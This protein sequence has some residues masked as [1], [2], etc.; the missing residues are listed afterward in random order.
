MKRGGFD[1]IIGNPPW[2][3]LSGKFGNQFLPATALEY[4]VS[5][6]F[7]NTYMPNMY[8]YFVARGLGLTKMS[9]LVGYIVP[10]RLGF[11]TQFIQLRRR[12]VKDAQIVTLYY[13]VPFPGVIAD[14]LVFVIRKGPAGLSHEVEISEYGHAAVRI[15]QSDFSLSPECRFEY[16][17]DTRQEQ[18]SRRIQSMPCVRPLTD[19]V[20]CTSGF[21]GKSQLITESQENERQIKTLKGSSIGRYVTHSVYWF[22]FKKENITGR[23]TNRE[24]LGAQP[25]LL[26]R[27]TGDSIVA[28]FDDSGIFPEQSLYFLYSNK[29]RADFKFFLGVINSRLLNWFFKKHCL[30]NERSIAQVKTVDLAKLPIRNIDFGSRADTTKHNH[31]VRLVEQML[32]AKQH[33]SAA[34]SDKDKDFYQNRCAGLDRQIDALVHELYGLTPEEI[35]IVEGAMI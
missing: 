8:E 18:M 3:S 4:L 33:L 13:K 22:E 26:I 34:K 12:I 5:T 17:I 9:G 28:T 30:T 35:Q 23:T 16:K 32:S 11:N 24:K 6:Y 20:S 15:K 19:L 29:T 31:V 21:G 25:K 14:T 7:G 2:I 1:A 27:K 10:D